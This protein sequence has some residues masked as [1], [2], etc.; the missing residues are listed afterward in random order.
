MRRRFLV[1]RN[2]G[3]T[4]IELL[5]FM[6]IVGIALAA[7]LNVFTQNVLHSNDPLIRLRALEL[8]Q[9]QLD[10]I[11]AR[12]FDENT[13]SGG[14][15][16]CGTLSGVVCNGIAPDGDFDDVGD[17]N[18]LIDNSHTGYSISIS[19]SDAGA[20]L[21][22]AAD[23]ARLITVTVNTPDTHASSTGS[24]IVLSAFKVNF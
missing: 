18:G 12:R 3:A 23:E 9:A 13:P 15:P 19:V 21:G 4:L 10:S 2:L 20:V 14:V 17:F 22:L 5:V 1:R 16:A 24:P 7:T 11:L 6:V 8:A